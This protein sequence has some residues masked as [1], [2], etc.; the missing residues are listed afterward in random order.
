MQ[1]AVALRNARADVIETNIGTSPLL[2]IYT[3]SPPGVA[4]TASGDL[5]VEMTL[6]SDWL[7]AASGGVKALAGDWSDTATGAG[8][9]GYYRI[10]TSGAA[11]RIEGTCSLFG[12]GGE[13]VLTNTAAIAISDAVSVSSFQ[14]TEGNA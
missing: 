13:L 8:V 2:R 10:L 9:P 5:L 11:S 4:E 1:F 6:P 3:G 14:T 7:A 12:G